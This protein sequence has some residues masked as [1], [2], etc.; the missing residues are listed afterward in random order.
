VTTPGA[1]DARPRLVRGGAGAE[2]VDAR[3]GRPTRRRASWVLVAVL[4]CALAAAALQSSRLARMTERADRLEA[5]STA[6]RSQLGDAQAQI[7]SFEKQRDLVR[8]SVADLAARVAALSELVKR[9]VAPAPAAPPAAE[10]SAQLPH[11]EG[12]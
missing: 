7:R 8:E 2:P 4:A 12:R 3:T 10:P 1:Q 9:G 5:E 6:L 11:P